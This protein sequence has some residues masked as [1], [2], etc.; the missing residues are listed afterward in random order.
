MG[1]VSGA[2]LSPR[3]WHCPEFPFLTTRLRPTGGF[4]SIASDEHAARWAG[5]S[6]SE[7]SA[8]KH[9]LV[10]SAFANT[11]HEDSHELEHDQRADCR[12]FV[13]AIQSDDALTETMRQLAEG[14]GEVDGRT[15]SGT[16]YVVVVSEEIARR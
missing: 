6:R 8:G 2:I 9:A 12:S 16:N 14:K 7:S 3:V 5:N 15:I 4:D 13:G 10:D 11:S 1:S